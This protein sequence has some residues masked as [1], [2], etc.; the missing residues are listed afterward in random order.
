MKILR[1]N[2]WECQGFTVQQNMD[3]VL[4]LVAGM[5]DLKCLYFLHEDASLVQGEI[6]ITFEGCLEGEQYRLSFVTPFLNDAD[7]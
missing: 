7:R 4:S 3:N 5:D 2:S 1:Y 6:N